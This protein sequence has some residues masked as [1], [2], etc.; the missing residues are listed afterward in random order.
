ME[1]NFISLKIK[2]RNTFGVNPNLT[3]IKL[4]ELS[5]DYAVLTKIRLYLM[6]S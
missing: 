1:I 5:I 4:C 3:L 6:V 2:K